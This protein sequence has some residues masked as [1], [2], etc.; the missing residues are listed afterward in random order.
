MTRARIFLLGILALFFCVGVMGIAEFW[1]YLGGP[2]PPWWFRLVRSPFLFW[3][4][5]V[6]LLFFWFEAESSDKRPTLPRRMSILAPLLFP[7]GIPYY[8]LR[9]Y[10]TRSAVLRIG[11]AAVFA[12]ACIAAIRLGSALTW[13]YYAVWTNNPR[14]S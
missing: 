1:L 3:T 8:F 5:L 2:R 11:L 14:T 4:C 13:E 9:T 6:A 7:I 12:V 10:P